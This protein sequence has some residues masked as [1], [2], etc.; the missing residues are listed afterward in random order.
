MSRLRVISGTAKGRKL[1]MVPGE[2]T[3]P[4]TDRVKQALF[5][6]IGSDEAAPSGSLCRNRQRDRGAEPGASG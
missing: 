6:I 2:G 1:R 5:N 3:R 4:V